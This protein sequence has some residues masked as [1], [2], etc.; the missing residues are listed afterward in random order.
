MAQMAQM[1]PYGAI[2]APYG[3]ITID[4]VI[5]RHMA[6]YGGCVIFWRHKAPYGD[7]A[8]WRHKNMAQSP[9]GAIWRLRHMAQPP[10]GTIGINTKF[11]YYTI[12]YTILYKYS[13]RPGQSEQ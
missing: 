6:P 2:S 7:C 3:A 13:Q 9:Y 1:A 5:W 4:G 10:Y 8:I 12:Y 11:I